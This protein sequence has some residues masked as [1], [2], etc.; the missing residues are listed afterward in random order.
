MVDENDN[1]FS[2]YFLINVSWKYSGANWVY[3]FPLQWMEYLQSSGSL[4]PYSSTE[5]NTF[6]SAAVEINGK[7]YHER[8]TSNS[9]SGDDWGHTQTFYRSDSTGKVYFSYFGYDNL[10]FDFGLK[11]NDTF[12]E[13]L[14]VTAIDSIALHNNGKEEND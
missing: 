12:S 9:P 13:S 3:G 7:D 14:V 4:H 5:R 8:L 6:D 2:T 1:W 11:L 10:I